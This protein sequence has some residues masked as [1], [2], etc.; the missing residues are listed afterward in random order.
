MHA[1]SRRRKH[2][3]ADKTIVKVVFVPGR[4]LNIVAK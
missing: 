3:C 2:D 4:L 1:F